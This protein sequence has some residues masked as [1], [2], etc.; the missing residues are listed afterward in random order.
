MNKFWDKWHSK[1]LALLRIIMGFLIFWHGTQ[2]LFG[3]PPTETAQGELSSL[4]LVAGI[5]E[6]LGGILLIIGLFTRWTAFILSGMMAVAYCM[7]FISK[8]FL[9][10]IN[11]GELSVLYCFIFFYLFFSGGG[12]FSI[13]NYFKKRKNSIIQ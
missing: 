8:S 9:P 2:K 10:I 5:L 11:G 6:F 7:V 4:L 3:Y 12:S 13:D 1:V